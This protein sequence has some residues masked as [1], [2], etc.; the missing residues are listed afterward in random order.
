ME[1]RRGGDVLRSAAGCAVYAEAEADDDSTDD[2][3][4]SSGRRLPDVVRRWKQ[5]YAE[6]S[7]DLLRDGDA[8][9]NR[10]G[11]ERNA[12]HDHGNGAM[13]YGMGEEA[14]PSGAASLMG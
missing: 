8:N 1:E 6:G 14:A 7:S 5:Q 13:R 10:H 11:D 2:G 9:G 12:D 4:G 3:A